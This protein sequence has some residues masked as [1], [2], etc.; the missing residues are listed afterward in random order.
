[1]NRQS[2]NRVSNYSLFEA[3]LESCQNCQGEAEEVMRKKK[4]LV[5]YKGWAGRVN[6]IVILFE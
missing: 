3:A 6:E 5:N 1:M 4:M 2:S